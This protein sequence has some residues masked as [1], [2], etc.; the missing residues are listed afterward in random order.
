MIS[1]TVAKAKG[2]FNHVLGT[3]HTGVDLIYDSKMLSPQCDSLEGI[4]LTQ[5]SMCYNLLNN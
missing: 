4:G 2:T 3:E 1:A 5:L